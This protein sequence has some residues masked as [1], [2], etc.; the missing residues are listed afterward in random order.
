MIDT[1]SALQSQVLSSGLTYELEAKEMPEYSGYF[2]S[3]FFKAPRAGNYRFYAAAD[4]SIDVYISTTAN[5]VNRAS[6]TR[7]AY[8][9]EWNLFRN[10]DN[11]K[12]TCDKGVSDYYALEEG[13]L[14]YMEVFSYNGGS[15]GYYTVSVEV[16]NPDTVNTAINSVPEV[17]Y[18]N[19]TYTPDYEKYSIKVWN[20][21]ASFQFQLFYRNPVS[22]V[23][24]WDRTTPAK[25]WSQWTAAEVRNYLGK[26]PFKL[27]I[28]TNS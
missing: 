13:K 15:A 18:F 28:P 6:M 22:R 11:G 21:N 24:Q 12:S 9:C 7:V 19:M 17:Q 20:F 14:Y 10:Y 5:V 27:L 1:P 3:G 4:D 25:T 16:P 26:L 2:V 8:N 23:V